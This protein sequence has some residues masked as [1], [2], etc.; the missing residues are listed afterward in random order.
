MLV[1]ESSTLRIEASAATGIAVLDPNSGSVIGRF[2][3]NT[4]SNSASFC[5]LVPDSESSFGFVLGGIDT[6][7]RIRWQATVQVSNQ[8]S[9]AKVHVFYEMRSLAKGSKFH[10]DVDVTDFI[11]VAIDE[12]IVDISS[13]LI[14]LR[15]AGDMAP[16]Q[17]DSFSFSFA[18]S[19]KLPKARFVSENVAATIEDGVLK[20]LPFSDLGGCRILLG[21]TDERT[22][23]TSCELRSQVVSEI[24]LQSLDAEATKLAIKNAN[25]DLILS[26]Q[27]DS[28]EP[29]VQK[30]D[31]PEFN[32]GVANLLSNHLDEAD[33]AF[34]LCMQDLRLRSASWFCL[35]LSAMRR[36]KWALAE[37][38]FS[39]SLLFNGANSLAWWLKNWCLRKQNAENDFDLSNAHFL[40]P[41]DPCLRADSFFATNEAKLLDGFGT[42]PHHFLDVAEWLFYSGQW[43]EMYSL[44]TEA[45]PRAPASLHHLLLAYAFT[46]IPDKQ[47][48][49]M[50]QIVFAGNCSN[51]VVPT[52][53]S[54]RFAVRSLSSQFPEINVLQGIEA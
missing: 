9:A 28:L 1:L 31:I 19:T 3:V 54:E 33:S 36:K 45:I 38:N 18:N 35:G 29:S 5:Q 14:R 2:L 47:M 7:T 23:E 40:A 30:I 10:I 34:L 13:N 6:R 15:G 50:E 41:L 12:R 39:E 27:S 51:Q 16:L 4:C 24:S 37:A 17:C 32:R 11:A 46:Q 43:E 8:T 25:G 44:L 22:V 52:R 20:L 48:A 42:N 53:M 49:A 21:L 26:T